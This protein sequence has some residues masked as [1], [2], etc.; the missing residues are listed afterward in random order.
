[1]K[2]I[3]DSLAGRQREESGQPRKGSLGNLHPGISS[4]VFPL[5]LGERKIPMI[6]PILITI[7]ALC[8]SY[9]S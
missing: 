6:V 9:F 2:G 1:M 8:A 5:V 4:L 7:I 3:F